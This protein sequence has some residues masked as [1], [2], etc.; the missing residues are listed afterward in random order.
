MRL[1]SAHRVG[2]RQ[3]VLDRVNLG[4][5]IERRG[6]SAPVQTAPPAVGDRRQHNGFGVGQVMVEGEARID[7][8]R[9]AA[10]SL[11]AAP[12][13]TTTMSPCHASSS[14]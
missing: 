6:H 2:R 7:P 1:R 5:G 14:R 3:G 8:A 4:L 13:L 11:I 10:V 9:V 12:W